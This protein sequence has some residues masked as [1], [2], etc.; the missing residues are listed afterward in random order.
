MIIEYNL[1]VFWFKNPSVSPP[2]EV[3]PRAKPKMSS[4]SQYISGRFQLCMTDLETYPET[5]LTKLYGGRRNK[6]IWID[7]YCL[8][9]DQ[10]TKRM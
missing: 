5:Y 8:N 10:E 4:K 7:S 1:K 9:H 2:M 3:R 6:K